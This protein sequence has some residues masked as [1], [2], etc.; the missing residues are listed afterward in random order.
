MN[1]ADNRIVNRKKIVPIPTISND[2]EEPKAWSLKMYIPKDMGFNDMTISSKFI[3][4]K[5]L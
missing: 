3:D 4:F 2:D 1:A 5:K